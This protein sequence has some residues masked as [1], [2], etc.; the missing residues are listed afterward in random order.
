MGQTYNPYDLT[1]T[2]GGSSGG[3]GAG[4]AATFGVLGTGSDT[5]QSTRSPAS[6]NSGVG[7]RPTFGLISRDGIIPIS[8]THDTAGPITRYVADAAVM[9]DY[10]VGFDPADASTWQGVGKA[11]ESYTAFLDAD[12]LEG[13]RI[14]YVVNVFGDGSHPEHA[15][16]TAA[17]MAAIE[18]MRKAGATVFPV[19]IPEVD[20]VARDDAPMGVSNFE[21]R[22]IMDQYFAN[23][24]PNAK[25]KS[26]AE[27]VAAAAGTHPPVYAALKRALESPAEI[28]RDPEFQIRL[29]R[30]AAFREALVGAMDEY[31]LDALFYTHQRRLVVPATKDPDQVERNGFLAAN[32]GLPAITVPGGFSP[33]SKDA[34]IGV[35]IGVE[36]LGRP[37]S[38]AELIRLAYGFERETAHRRPPPSTPSLPGET[39]TY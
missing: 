32:S 10:L 27:Y 4:I 34:P 19:D 3:T 24:G 13:A 6:A 36:F 38:E 26:L 8:Y 31:G 11:P 30:Q 21:T 2:P 9:M 14:G 25:Y 12:S 16:V 39:F 1:R 35:P 33:P 20:A 17:T 37:F 29:E 28:I 5:G 18:A 22:W 15:V 23:L 7:I